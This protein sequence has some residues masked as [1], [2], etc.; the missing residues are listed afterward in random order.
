MVT[1]EGVAG[2]GKTGQ[3]VQ[4]NCRGTSD[5]C[6]RG[7]HRYSVTRYSDFS[8]GDKRLDLH[9]KPPKF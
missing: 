5:C 9:A 4:S 8:R 3:H 1:L 2:V 7:E 6:L